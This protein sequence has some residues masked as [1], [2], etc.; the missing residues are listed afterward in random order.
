M[1][2]QSS[3][4]LEVYLA[5]RVL[6]ALPLAEPPGRGNQVFGLKFKFMMPS[7]FKK[8]PATK[9]QHFSDPPAYYIPSKRASFIQH[10]TKVKFWYLQY[11]AVQMVLGEFQVLHFVKSSHLSCIF[12]HRFIDFEGSQP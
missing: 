1:F 5:H 6:K 11:S 3:F 8:A 2:N 10:E 4:Y 9:L 7:V 12:H